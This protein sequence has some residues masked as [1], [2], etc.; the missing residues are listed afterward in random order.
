MVAV[1]RIGKDYLFDHI[2]GY[3]KF[4][5]KKIDGLS[6]Q[7]N[8]VYLVTDDGV[9]LA[10][11]GNSLYIPDIYVNLE[12]DLSCIDFKSSWVLEKLSSEPGCIRNRF[13][14]H[15]INNE[16]ISFDNNGSDLGS[17]KYRISR[18][19]ESYVISVLKTETYGFVHHEYTSD[20][21]FYDRFFKEILEFK[22]Y[23]EI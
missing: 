11:L 10:L 21:D 1:S 23:E 14:H 13:T 4:T 7:G 19:D 17:G 22:E 6:W 2:S 18:E 15:H 5:K 20:L 9:Y 16:W 8:V 3:K 12:L